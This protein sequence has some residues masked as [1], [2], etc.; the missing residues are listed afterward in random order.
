[1]SRFESSVPK[2]E[3]EELMKLFPEHDG[4]AED[5]LKEY[6]IE[7]IMSHGKRNER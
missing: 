3:Q 1:M 2:K 7:R 5:Q 6:E 4:G